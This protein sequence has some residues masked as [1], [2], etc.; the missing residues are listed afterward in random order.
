MNLQIKEYGESLAAI[1]KEAIAASTAPLLVRIAEL[2][3]KEMPAPVL[4]DFATLVAAEVEKQ[5]AAMPKPK[6]G[7]PGRDADESLIVE[8]MLA[9]IPTPANGA[10]GKDGAN[11]LD[12]APGANGSDGKDGADG[13]SGIDGAKGLDGRNG[14]D[15][16]DAFDLEIMPHIDEAKSYRKGS[17]ASHK[18]GLWVTR[19]QSDGMDG[20]ECIVDGVADIVI[21]MGEDQRAIEVRTMMASGEVKA[22]IFTTPTMIYRDLFKEG[23]I[24]LKGDVVTWAGHM[25]VCKQ[26]TDAKPVEGDAWR[27]AVKRGQDGK[28]VH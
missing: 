10:D 23:R 16:R 1:V 5:V 6:D 26:D 4:P 9:A 2:E 8:R 20:W 19:R 21:E 25:W 12:G 22:A 7:E 11:G 17:Y 27:I 18:G 28:A 24:Y 15:G 13:R 3:G 14:T